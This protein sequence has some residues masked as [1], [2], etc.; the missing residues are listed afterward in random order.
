[1]ADQQP[2][3]KSE[4]FVFRGESLEKILD[5][6][7]ELLD[8]GN[9]RQVILKNSKGETIASFPLTAGVAAG[10]VGLAVAPILAAIAA[11]AALV[12]EMSITVE[13]RA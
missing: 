12:T 2:P 3:P 1:M 7:R 13:K 4:T 9:V 10:V 11:I 5:R 6:I 8:E